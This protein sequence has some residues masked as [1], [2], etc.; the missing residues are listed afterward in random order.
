VLAAPKSAQ[1]E[2]GWD[3]LDEWCSGCGVT[4]VDGETWDA[5]MHSDLTLAASGTVTVEAALLGTPMVTFYKVSSLTWWI[6][7]PLVSVPFYSMVNIVAQRRIVPELIQD[8]M[9]AAALLDEAGKLLS[10]ADARAAMKA[11]LAQVRAALATGRDPLE[12]SAR[13]IAAASGVSG[14]L[15]KERVE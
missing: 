4:R 2:E 15:E 8:G 9:T 1:G 11:E 10:N 5:M 13:R 3:F 14:L 12:T 7:R 6:G